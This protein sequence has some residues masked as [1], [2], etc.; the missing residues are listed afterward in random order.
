MGGK[1]RGVF[2]DFRMARVSGRSRDVSYEDGGMKCLTIVMAVSIP[3]EC[4]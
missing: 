3:N 4:T 2:S 1:G